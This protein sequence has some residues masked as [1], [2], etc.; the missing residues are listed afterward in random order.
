MRKP[1]KI[2]GL[3]AALTACAPNITR[4][5]VERYA[6][7]IVDNADEVRFDVVLTSNDTRPLCV[8]IENW[9]NPS[10]HFTVEKEDAFV[11]IGAD[12]LPIKSKLVSAYCPGGCG[13]YRIEPRGE[14]R[15]FIAYEAFGDAS[16]LAENEEKELNFPVSPY[17]CR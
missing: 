14:L 6:L 9:P 4:P 13:E 11:K 16:R 17:Y 2:L 3:L 1:L 5:T 10:G 8:A 12:V 15:G 7:H